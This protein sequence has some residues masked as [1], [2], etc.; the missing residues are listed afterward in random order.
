MSILLDET[1]RV[2]VQGITGR[3]A[4]THT[5]YMRACGT[6]V[7]AGV[8]PGKGGST[9]N[10]I[11]VFDTVRGAVD[12]EGG[13]AS[14]LFVPGLQAFEAAAEA[15]DAALGLVVIL[16]E[17]VPLH[18]ASRLFALARMR[19]VRVIGPN[20]VGIIS[21]GRAK[22]GGVGGTPEITAKLFRPGPVGV[23]SRSGGMGSEICWLLSREGI[24]QTTYVGIGGDSM[25]GSSFRD[26]LALFGADPL[27]R[28]VVMFGEPGTAYEEEAADFVRAGGFA[29]PLVALVVGRVYE[30][31]PRGVA[32]GHA[33]ALVE[34]GVGSALDK[35]EALRRAGVAVADRMSQIPGLVRVA[36]AGEPVAGAR[37][38]A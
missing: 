25:I 12:A 20:S 10:G 35:I 9:M 15:I 7:V 13:D 26:L 18:D 1:T 2:I 31:L 34:R 23:V 37:G 16:A 33:S 21:P 36:L 24:G 22:V 38:S 14:V 5:E 32:F 6:R 29:K 11:P 19:G 17:G 3:E 27:T 4:R 8:A 28:A 30:K